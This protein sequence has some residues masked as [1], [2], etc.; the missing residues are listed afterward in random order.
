MSGVGRK[1]AGNATSRL[2]DPILDALEAP[3]PSPT[4]GSA[5]A[6]AAAMAAALLVMVARA[7]GGDSGAALQ[8]RALRARLVELADADVSAYAAVLEAPR[9]RE[10]ASALLAATEPPAAIAE[11]A[12]EVCELAA[13]VRESAK[14]ALRGDA[15]IAGLLAEAAA[16][17]AAHLVEVNLAGFPGTS[18]ARHEH[19]PQ[20]AALRERCRTACARA[21]RTHVEAEQLPS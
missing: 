3:A 5:A 1:A 12:A 6:G 7:A 2:L 15:A 4:G 11:S 10:F 21:R 13:L 17:G 14:P 20:I 9:G 8:A 18:E 16:L 19:A